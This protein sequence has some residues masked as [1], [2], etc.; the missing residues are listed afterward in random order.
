MFGA[1][2]PPTTWVNATARQLERPAFADRVLELRAGAG[3]ERAALGIEV[4]VTAL[5]DPA[6]DVLGALRRLAEAGV[7]LAVDDFG[8]GRTAVADLSACPLTLV[9]ID[10]SFVA[11]P[12]AGQGLPLV[13]ALVELGHALG[14]KVCAQ[15]VETQAQLEAVRQAGADMASG[16]HLARPVPAHAVR[17]AARSGEHALAAVRPR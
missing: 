10:R 13:A 14:A 16:F 8:A 7:P 6:P 2:D 4:P 3:A 1:A 17:A 15:G 9:K 12:G 5:G 11:G